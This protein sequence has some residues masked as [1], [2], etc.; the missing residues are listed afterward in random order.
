MRHKEVEE[1]LRPLIFDFFF[2]FSRFES[3]LNENSWL[4]SQ[5]VGAT[6]LADWK[7]FVEAYGGDYAPSDAAGSLVVANP[8]KQ[9]VGDAG[10]TFN[11]VTFTDSAS[12]LDRVTLLLMTARNNLFHGGKHGSAYWDDSVRIRLLLP[13]CITM[14]EELAELGGMQAD[15]IGYY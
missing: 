8:Q 7:G 4:Q 1:D 3:A 14:L 13:L 10:L 6:A 15:H 2:W 11:D 12:Q 9:I 5:T